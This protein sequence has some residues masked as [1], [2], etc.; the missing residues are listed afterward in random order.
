[1]YYI[2]VVQA[3]FDLKP[4]GPVMYTMKV[5]LKRF[6]MVGTKI[7][8]KLE[9]KPTN[10]KFDI[11]CYLMNF[12][13]KNFIVCIETGATSF[14]WMSW[15]VFLFYEWSN[16]TNSINGLLY[17]TFL[18]IL[19]SSPITAANSKQLQLKLV[20]FNIFFMYFSFMMNVT[21]TSWSYKQA[22]VYNYT[23]VC[24]EQNL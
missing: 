22:C 17:V 13:Q 15:I 11:H 19:C 8:C 3:N 14:T 24:I 6:W 18:I 5:D 12:L 2:Y 20:I 10:T 21:S 23:F 4:L 1:M 9:A 16:E 7:I